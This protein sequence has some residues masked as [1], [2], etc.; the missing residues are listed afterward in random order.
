MAKP[1]WSISSGTSLT[2]LNK[3]VGLVFCFVNWIFGFST[4]CDG[5]DRNAT[6]LK[7]YEN[8]AYV[9]GTT[10]IG[11][12]T[13]FTLYGVVVRQWLY[14]RKC[15]ILMAVILI[16]SFLH[17]I[18]TAMLHFFASTGTLFRGANLAVAVCAW[19]SVN[20]Y[21]ICQFEILFL[22]SPIVPIWTEK[23]IFYMQIVSVPVQILMNLPSYVL[24]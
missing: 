9:C 1:V 15:T 17:T 16:F 4:T 7:E 20:T 5:G 13:L 19:F 11:L 23:R 10:F 18:A 14:S 3:V 2:I 22:F 6:R 8:I 21:V 24:Y 12:T